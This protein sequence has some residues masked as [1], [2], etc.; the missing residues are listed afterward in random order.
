MAYS[1]AGQHSSQTLFRSSS[2]SD[3]FQLLLL[4]PGSLPR[5]AR[6]STPHP[7]PGARSGIKEQDAWMGLGIGIAQQY[8]QK[9]RAQGKAPICC[10]HGPVMGT[11]SSGRDVQGEDCGSIPEP[12]PMLSP[13]K[14]PGLAPPTCPAPGWSSLPACGPILSAWLPTLPA[15]VLASYHGDPITGH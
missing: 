14:I 13:T 7:Q 3:S 15:R 10:L 12:S 5:H 1:G 8:E 9:A 11:R 4:D 2:S 6:P